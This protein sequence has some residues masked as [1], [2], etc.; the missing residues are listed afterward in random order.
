MAARELTGASCG[1]GKQHQLHGTP[2]GRRMQSLAVPPHAV[3]SSAGQPG[4]AAWNRAATRLLLLRAECLWSHSSRPPRPQLRPADV[5]DRD[6]PSLPKGERRQVSPVT[7]KLHD[8]LFFQMNFGKMSSMDPTIHPQHY[9]CIS[10]NFE[11]SF[12]LHTKPQN[13]VAS[14]SPSVPGRLAILPHQKESRAGPTR[15]VSLGRGTWHWNKTSSATRQ[16]C[17]S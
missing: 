8:C 14:D 3:L 6:R 9:F 1:S 13:A 2:C 16:P 12:S 7:E 17:G 5:G 11:E 10:R 15:M 4:A